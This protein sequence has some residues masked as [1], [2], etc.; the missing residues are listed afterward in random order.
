[1]EEISDFILLFRPLPLKF[2]TCHILLG[3][4]YSTAT[5]T[6]QG[7]N[8]TS[9]ILGPKKL[10]RNLKI[11]NPWPLDPKVEENESGGGAAPC[12]N[13]S[14]RRSQSKESRV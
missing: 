8:L 13:S 3:D 12:V 4:A 2:S 9:K 11:L 7:T 14:S 5:Y 1:M 6:S 10:A